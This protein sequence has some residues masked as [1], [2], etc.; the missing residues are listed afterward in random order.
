MTAPAVVKHLNV[1]NDILPGKR[2]A[3]IPLPKDLL[4]FEAAEKT[5]GHSIIPAI[6]F[7]AH[8]V[9]YTM[10]LKQLLEIMA[11]IQAAPVR[12]KDKAPRR[13][14]SPNRHG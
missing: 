7:S 1:I 4:N 9:Q 2:P 6:T 13:F 12:M 10:L 3:E 14:S 5:L 8:T 11:A